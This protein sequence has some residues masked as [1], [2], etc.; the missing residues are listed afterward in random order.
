ME[1]TGTKISMGTSVCSNEIKVVCV[2]VCGGGGD[3]LGTGVP[4]PLQVKP[5]NKLTADIS[6][7]TDVC[8]PVGLQ[9]EC[10]IFA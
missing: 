4:V 3:D 8:F 7:F 2:C 9:T 6:N 10:I 5:L 1:R